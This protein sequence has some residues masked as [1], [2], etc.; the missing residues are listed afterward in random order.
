MAISALVVALAAPG[1]AS[2]AGRFRDDDHSRHEDAIETVVAAGI[3]KPCDPPVNDRF[4][5]GGEVTRGEMAQFLVRA[6]DLTAT[7]GVRYRDV[8]K[9]QA[10]AVDKVVTAGIAAP[11]EKR[12]FCA[13]GEVTRGRLASYLA[14]AL[15][16][17]RQGL[18]NKLAKYGIREG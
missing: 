3:M 2:A 9:R 6:F 10:K 17:S 12:R 11:C 16:L 18:H 13:R 4:C 1:T 7:S 5:P 15:G 8:P 14:K